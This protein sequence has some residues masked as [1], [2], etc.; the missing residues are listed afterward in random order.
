MAERR[1]SNAPLEKL[2]ILRIG[3]IAA[4][5]DVY[6]DGTI[7]RVGR[8]EQRILLVESRIAG[9]QLEKSVVVG[10]ATEIRRR[11][12]ELHVDPPVGLNAHQVNG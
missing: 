10:W 8:Q 2:R 9:I 6:P 7:S 3:V 5:V 12:G 1:G 4:P 11:H